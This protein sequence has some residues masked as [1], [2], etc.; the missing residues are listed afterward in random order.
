VRRQAPKSQLR[1]RRFIAFLAVA[2]A[3]QIL[4]WRSTLADQV[5]RPVVGYLDSGS[6]DHNWAAAFREGLREAGY[7]EDDNVAIEYRWAE[8]HYD[9]L[10][11]LATDLVRRRVAVLVATSTPPAIAAKAAT[12]T[13]P[14]V[15]TTGSDP[16]AFGLVA[17]L[18]QPGGNLT[19]ITRMNLQIGPKRL[20]LL[21]Q[22]LPNATDVALLMNPTNPNATILSREVEATAAELGLHVRELRAQTDDDLTA[23]F[24]SLDQTGTRALLVG[25]DP[26]FNSRIGRLAALTITHAIPTV[27]QYREFAAAGGLLSYGASLSDAH[28]QVGVYTR[29][30]LAGARPADLPVQQSTKIELIL[31]LRTANALRLDVPLPLLARADEVIE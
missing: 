9:R 4:A 17:S 2:S 30:I 5:A 15:F 24:A 19:G 29:R 25:P 23:A 3:P 27:Y 28:R 1:R 26:F 13:I 31:N 21:H 10:P 18:S 22:L 14:V 12:T 8:G 6:P 11:D 20:E 16:V 7:I